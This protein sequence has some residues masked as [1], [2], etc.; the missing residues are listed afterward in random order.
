MVFN[1]RR[2]PRVECVLP[3]YWSR[4]KVR[5]EGETR[6][7]NV[8]GVFI[9]TPHDAPI[10][11]MMDLVIV[12]PWGELTCTAVPR[13]AGVTPHGRGLGIEFHVMDRGD[14]DRWTAHYR[15]VLAEREPAT[16]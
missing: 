4:W 15:R 12:M 6:R 7:C 14:R 13:F 10:G 2:S 8:H 5:Q 11:F 16:G 9:H 3:V 1:P